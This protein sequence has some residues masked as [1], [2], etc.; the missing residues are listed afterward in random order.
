MLSM[1]ETLINWKDCAES[2]VP[3]PPLHVAQA[4][5]SN[6]C[7]HLQPVASEG[8]RKDAERHAGWVLD[9]MV[10]DVL[11]HGMVALGDSRARKRI[12]LKRMT[13]D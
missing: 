11:P 13:L 8:E 9:L 12:H 4:P 3:S 2:K 6:P 7:L 10:L 5:A 1:L